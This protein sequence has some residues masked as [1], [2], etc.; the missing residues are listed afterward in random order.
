MDHLEHDLNQWQA[1]AE[2]EKH[3]MGEVHHFI[4][5]MLTHEHALTATPSCE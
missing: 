3:K 5:I 4:A 2:G 1:R